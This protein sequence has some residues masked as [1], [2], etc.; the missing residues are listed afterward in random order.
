MN[1]GTTHAGFK[2]LLIARLRAR[3]LAS[4]TLRDKPV[5]AVGLCAKAPVLESLCGRPLTMGVFQR[6]LLPHGDVRV[7]A[8]SRMSASRWSRLQLLWRRRRALRYA[9]HVHVQR[10]LATTSVAHFAF[11]LRFQLNVN[12]PRLPHAARE[13]IA[14]SMRKAA[15]PH[16]HTT[17][18]EV[19]M[20]SGR[21]LQGPYSSRNEIPAT[22][23]EQ[24]LP[25]A[26]F[27]SSPQTLAHRSVASTER[28]SILRLRSM[29]EWTRVIRLL[30]S[31]NAP[32]VTAKSDAARAVPMRLRDGESTQGVHRSAARA[33]ARAA[34]A[35]RRADSANEQSRPSIAQLRHRMVIPEKRDDNTPNVFHSRRAEITWRRERDDASFGPPPSMR[36]TASRSDAFNTHAAATS[37]RAAELVTA[38]PTRPATALRLDSATADRLAEDVIQRVERRVRIE[39]ERRGL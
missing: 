26:G 17:R 21:D 2:R 5:L 12:A 10:M 35:W 23:T 19:L 9:N 28:H 16:W 32:R 13:G 29:R 38:L 37:N 3:L 24:M 20:R 36:S 27:N 4:G 39:R 1:T 22:G 6:G 33:P 18:R 7:E 31:V 15:P 14:A 25:P 8:I 30:G 11:N 34:I